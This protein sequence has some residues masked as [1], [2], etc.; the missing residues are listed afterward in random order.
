VRLVLLSLQVFL[1]MS[2]PLPQA[3]YAAVGVGRGAG[4]GMGLLFALYLLSDAVVFSTTRWLVARGGRPGVARLRAWLPERLG[5]AVADRTS[6]ARVAPDGWSGLAAV[7]AAG[8][9][10]LYLA[11][12]I[13]GLSGRRTLTFTVAGIAGDLVQF[14]GAIALAGVLARAMGVP[15]GSWIALM[16]APLVVASLPG[17]PCAY[18]TVITYLRRPRPAFLLV[19]TIHPSPVP[20]PVRIDDGGAVR[21]WE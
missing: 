17:W 10:N 15:G 9:A 12:L 1:L 8:Y 6:K 4:L 11:A 19:P 16:T 21:H 5:R 14:S 18:R 20:V 2:T 13:T 7:F 3:S